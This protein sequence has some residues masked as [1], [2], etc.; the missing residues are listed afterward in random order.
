MT[1][2]NLCIR[3]IT[4]PTP[5]LLGGGVTHSAPP[6][7][8]NPQHKKFTSTMTKTNAPARVKC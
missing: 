4:E 2:P 3:P 7:I 1:T 8:V 5:H 6:L